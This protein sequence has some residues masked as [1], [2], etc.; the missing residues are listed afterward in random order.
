MNGQEGFRISDAKNNHYMAVWNSQSWGQSKFVLQ[1]F[2]F[3]NPMLLPLGVSYADVVVDPRRR[4][5]PC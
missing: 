1:D 5:G 4:Q 2:W 3:R